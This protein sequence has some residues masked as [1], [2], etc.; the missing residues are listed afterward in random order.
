MIGPRN[1]CLDAWNRYHL[2]ITCG[3]IIAACGLSGCATPVKHPPILYQPSDTRCL[4]IMDCIA[5]GQWET[6]TQT[7]RVEFTPTGC[8]VGRGGDPASVIEGVC[9]NGQLI[10]SG[11]E[12]GKYF[13]KLIES[14]PTEDTG[15]FLYRYVFREGI[16]E[17]LVFTVEG[18][19]PLYVGTIRVVEGHD[20]SPQ[21][22]PHT[23]TFNQ[24]MGIDTVSISTDA[25]AEMVAWNR[26]MEAFGETGWGSLVRA[27]GISGPTESK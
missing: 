3:L 6:V 22:Q 21:S 23:W 17:D 7:R 8:A 10:F 4:A 5:Y 27:K 1:T 14:Q 12:P 9:W 26:F 25:Q 24:L 20:L 15:I 19:E 18:G 2:V 13:L 16:S 11:L